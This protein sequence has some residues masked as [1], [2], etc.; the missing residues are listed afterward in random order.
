MYKRILVATDFSRH[1][2]RAQQEAARIGRGG[3][4]I[5]LH[6]IDPYYERLPYMVSTRLS[7]SEIRKGMMAR[8]KKEVKFFG[9]SAS[10]VSLRIA[11]GSA[12]REILKLARQERVDLIVLGTHGRIGLEHLLLG[13]VAEKIIRLAPCPVLTLR[14]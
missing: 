13:S 3:K 6:V 4:V 9:P 14:K 8:L 2:R 10:N 12:Y 7:R 11:V 5:L 1:S